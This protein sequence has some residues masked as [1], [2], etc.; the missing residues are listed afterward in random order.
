MILV[1]LVLVTG[2][3]STFPAGRPSTTVSRRLWYAIC[4]GICPNYDVTVWADGRV[5]VVRRSANPDSRRDEVE[6]FR[7][8]SAEAAEFQRRLLPFRPAGQLP[9]P[10]VCYHADVRAEEAPL[11]L[12][13]REVEINWSDPDHPARLVACDN[14]SGQGLTEAIRQALWSIHLYVNARRRD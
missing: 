7:V 11:V 6:R 9:E 10:L 8:S 3:V 4:T 14:A 2:C 5:L 12:K 13:V 1:G